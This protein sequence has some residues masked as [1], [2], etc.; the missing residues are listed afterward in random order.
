MMCLRKSRVDCGKSG[1][2]HRPVTR[3]YHGVIHV[4]VFIDVSIFLSYFISFAL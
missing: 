3:R 2:Q 1:S 4:Y